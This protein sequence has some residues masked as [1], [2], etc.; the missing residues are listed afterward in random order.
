MVDFDAYPGLKTEITINRKPLAE[1]DNDDVETSTAEVDKYIAARTEVEFVI[2]TTFKNP[3]PRDNGVE[4]TCSVDGHRA[5][6]WGIDPDEPTWY[7]P[8]KMKGMTLS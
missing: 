8:K 6:C 4:I 7:A 5:V 2:K 1:Y 3:F